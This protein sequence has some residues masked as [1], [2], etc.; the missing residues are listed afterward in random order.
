MNLRHSVNRPA[1]TERGFSMIDVL[2]SIVVMATALLALAVLQGTLTRNTADSRARTQ[3]AQLGDSLIDR[4]RQLGYANIANGATTIAPTAPSPVTKCNTP[5]LLATAAELAYCTQQASGVTGLSI[6]QTVSTYWFASKNVPDPVPSNCDDT[7]KTTP[8]NCQATFTSATPEY[9]NIAVVATWTDAAGTSRTLTE[10]TIVSPRTAT[11]SST[12]VQRD[13]GSGGVTTPAVRTTNPAVPGVIPIAISANTDTAATNPK[14]EL[15]TTTNATSYN[16]LTYKNLANSQVQ[17]QQRVETNV[18]GCS[19]QYG[20][21]LSTSSG[22]N[23]VFRQAWRPTYWDGLKYASP[24]PAAPPDAGSPTVFALAG[25]DPN[26]AVALPLPN[27]QTSPGESPLCKFCCR[28]HHEYPNDKISTDPDTLGTLSTDTIL[29]DP[30]RTD[31]AATDADHKHYRWDTS[32]TPNAFTPVPTTDTTNPYRES[33]RMIRVDGIWRTAADLN[34]EQVGFVATRTEAEANA[35]ANPVIAGGSTLPQT[36]WIPSDSAEA[37][38]QTFVKDYFDQKIA[39]GG[40]PNADDLY[41]SEGLDN[42]AVLDITTTPPL[43][44]HVRGLYLDHLEDAASKQIQAAL[45]HCPTG[46]TAIECVLPYIP[47]TSI[48]LS[49]LTRWGLPYNGVGFDSKVQVTNGSGQFGQFAGAGTGAAQPIRGKV[50]TASSGGPKDD[51]LIY[52]TRSNSGVAGYYPSVDKILLDGTGDASFAAHWSGDPTTGPTGSGAIPDHTDLQKFQVT[53]GNG[54]PFTVNLLGLPQTADAVTNNDPLVAWFNGVNLSDS[55]DCTTSYSQVDSNPS[56]YGCYT[57][58]NL[59]VGGAPM[60]V[61][62]QN[63]IRIIYKTEDDPCDA[64]QE[65]VQH[66]YCEYSQVSSATVNGVALTP[67]TSSITNAGKVAEST[68]ISIPALPKNGVVAIYF[69]AST[70]AEVGATYTCGT[71]P[72]TGNPMFLGFDP[73]LCQ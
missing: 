61:G 63:Y 49:E 64:T 22:V 4:Q 41:H 31:Y 17:L 62:V 43:W 35:A 47:F 15:Q 60:Q 72:V 50:T 73:P 69:T 56:P 24:A 65:Q 42:P 16:V 25:E 55:N 32:V 59:G 6:V 14:P 40:S 66:P 18:I 34:T 58:V 5:E 44:L 30:F 23:A 46:S 53:A 1:R 10:N 8:G 48:N 36:N 71:D 38:Y 57:D 39:Q 37:L 45:D 9:K 27:G 11:S 28:D 19:C 3:L 12:L 26:A 70:P 67:L 52:I 20:Q 51:L 21:A 13:Y 54:D 29:F 68:Q 2:V 7:F 33:C